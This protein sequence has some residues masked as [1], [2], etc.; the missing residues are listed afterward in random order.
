VAYSE[1]EVRRHLEGRQT[2]GIYPLLSDGRCWLMAIDLDGPTWPEDV[3]ALW[4]AAADA[5]VP[6][7]VERSRS[8]R[9]AHVWALFSQP[10]PA[11][12]ARAV[13]TWVLTQAMR[14]RAISMDAYD[15]LF[16]NQDTMPAGGFGT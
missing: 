9:G 7:L 11:R 2:I 6:V 5:G 4:D 16:P 1:T 8:G 13:G 12:T 15:R 10:V 14:R 3:A